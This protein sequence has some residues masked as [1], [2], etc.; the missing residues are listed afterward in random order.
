MKAIPKPE[1]ATFWQRLMAFMGNR[2]TDFRFHRSRIALDEGKDRLAVTVEGGPDAKGVLRLRPGPPAKPGL[3]PKYAPW[4]LSTR[5]GGKVLRLAEV[6]RDEAAWG[7]Q[8]VTVESSRW[9]LLERL[10]PDAKLLGATRVAPIDYVW[11]I[12]QR[13]P[14]A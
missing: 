9:A 11:R 14:L 3:M 4:G 1:Y 6:R 8:P 5:R 2:M 7:E 13:V 12:G 10:A